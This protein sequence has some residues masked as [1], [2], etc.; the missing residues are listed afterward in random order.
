MKSFE[1]KLINLGISVIASFF[2]WLLLIFVHDNLSATSTPGVIV[3]MM[4]GTAGG[5]IQIMTY[6]A[7]IFGFLELREKKKFLTMQ[8]YGINL[9][10]LPKEETTELSLKDI[11]EIKSSIVNLEARGINYLVNQYMKKICTQ[12]ANGESIS[13]ALQIFEYQI[14]TSKEEFEGQLEIVRYLLQAISSLGFIG[15]VLGLSVAI[16]MGNQ[17]KTE[18]G[19]KLITGNLNVAFDTTIV[20]LILG[21]ILTYM[22]HTYLEK[23]DLFF[24]HTKAYMVDNLITRVKKTI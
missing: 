2:I 20:A 11:S 1:S 21:L 6:V 7:F 12:F 16:G 4:G 24:S 10:L 13:D 23:L 17:A 22:Y 9:N 14:N 18:Q 3:R 15:T 8:Y 5:F 19:M